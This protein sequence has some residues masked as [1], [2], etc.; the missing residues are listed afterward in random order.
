[1]QSFLK[2]TLRLVLRY[3]ARPMLGPPVSTAIQRQWIWLLTRTMLTAPGVRRSVETCGG[4]PCER[5]QSPAG[6]SERAV[7]YLHG[8]AYVLGSP[9]SHRALTSHLAVFADATVLVPEYRL[10]PEHPY[11]AALD[12]ALAAYL[13]LLEQF[14]PEHIAISGD[15]AGGGLALA[16]AIAL[17]DRG[18]PLPA[19]LVLIAPWVDLSASGESM[20]T[21]A[22]RDVMLRGAWSVTSAAMYRGTFAADDPLLSPLFADLRGLPPTLIQI[23]SEEILFSDAERLEQ[24]LKAAGVAVQRQVFEGLWHVFHLHAR[25][26]RESDAAIFDMAAFMRTAWDPSTAAATPAAVSKNRKAAH[27]A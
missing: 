24:A 8:G 7:L 4:S 25:M 6:G 23:G 22:A 13:R 27:H 15:S 26:L 1:M 10:A 9:A 19:A 18:H 20:R 16:L 21:R 14:A 2:L 12:D 5:L 11:P 3:L 17:R